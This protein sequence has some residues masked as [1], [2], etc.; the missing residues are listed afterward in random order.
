MNNHLKLQ[1]TKN[2]ATFLFFLNNFCRILGISI[3]GLQSGGKNREKEK[4]NYMK[5]RFTFILTVIMTV[6]MLFGSAF[7][8][9][10]VEARL[11]NSNNSVVTFTIEEST[12][13]GHFS[14]SYAGRDGI[15]TYAKVTV[16]V[17]KRS[18][19]FLWIDVDTWSETSTELQGNFYTSFVLEG[20]GTYKASYTLEF[21]GT[22]SEVDVIENSITD[23]Y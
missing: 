17:Q 11:T 14:V 23:S 3:R 8:A 4:E 6:S 19:W 2:S 1:K 18:L 13:I 15:F 20:S 21:Y 12:G 7:P 5:K 22:G 16:K 9:S 10:A